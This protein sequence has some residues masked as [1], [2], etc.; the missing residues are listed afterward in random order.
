MGVEAIP[1]V[2]MGGNH[3]AEFAKA[4]RTKEAHDATLHVA[5]GLALVGV[6]ALS[7]DVFF[8]EVRGLVLPMNNMRNRELLSNLCR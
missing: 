2:P 6:R 3:T 5:R 1:T 4:A 7:D 8:S